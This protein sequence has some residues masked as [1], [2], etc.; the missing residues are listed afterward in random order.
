MFRTCTCM[1]IYALVA[2]TYTCVFVRINNPYGLVYLYVPMNNLQL[3]VRVCCFTHKYSVN[4]RVC[5]LRIMNLNVYVCVS[6]DILNPCVNL[7]V[8]EH[9]N[10]QSKA[11]TRADSIVSKRIA[12]TAFRRSSIIFFQFPTAHVAARSQIKHM[13]NF[14]I[15]RDLG[16]HRHMRN[17]FEEFTFWLLYFMKKML[18]FLQKTF[19]N[20]LYTDSSKPSQLHYEESDYR[21][22]RVSS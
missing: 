16:T 11:G 7:Y 8:C 2:Q 1:F 12:W 22:Y 6:V 17:F 19:N 13:N 15:G 20:P 14:L 9:I 10:I 18:Y 4:S 21:P 3:R 5:S